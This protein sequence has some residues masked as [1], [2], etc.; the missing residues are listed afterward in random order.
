MFWLQYAWRPRVSHEEAEAVSNEAEQMASK[1]GDIRSRAILLAI[2]GGI[3]GI[4]DG[5]V[6]EMAVVARQSTALAE[7]SGDPA[8]FMV[9]ASSSYAFFNIGEYREVITILDRALEL[10]AGDVSVGAGINIGCPYAYSLIFKGGALLYLGALDEG[11]AL[12]E[13]GMEIANDEGDVE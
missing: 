9:T 6:Q 13:H 8:L 1:A 12:I 11:R 3:R 2:Y 5:D 10:A 7:E 4:N